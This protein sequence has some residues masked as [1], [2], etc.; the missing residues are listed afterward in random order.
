MPA[1]YSGDPSLANLASPVIMQ[2]PVDSDPQ[3]AA[4]YNVNAFQLL[5]D[6]AD[7]YRRSLNTSVRVVWGNW[8]SPI[9]ANDAYAGDFHVSWTGA[10]AADLHGAIA[11]Y[12]APYLRMQTPANGN[13]FYAASGDSSS[14]VYPATWLYSTFE[15]D[16]MFDAIGAN[17]INI[18]AGLSNLPFS[19]NFS[20][21]YIRKNSADTKFQCCT[22]DGAATTV[23]DSG[24]TPVA[25]A[26]YR[27]RIDTFGSGLAGGLRVAFYIDG[28]LVA[29]NT[30]HINT[31]SGMSAS[32]TS[33]AVVGTADRLNVGRI[34]CEWNR[35]TGT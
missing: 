21:A 26:F 22:N 18:N 3:A 29:T 5:T 33:T 4:T 30:T 34:Y 32:V 10:T 25:N 27:L 13:T 7:R 8:S 16:V 31:A 20:G 17:N 9:A 2:E 14:L 6:Q 15:A 23:T 1:P 35:M 19:A 28:A 11:G 24:I 12:A